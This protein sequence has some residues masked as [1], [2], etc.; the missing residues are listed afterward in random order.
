MQLYDSIAGGIKVS[1]P[2]YPIE[3]VTHIKP[4]LKESPNVGVPIRDLDED[5]T[6][7]YEIM[8]QDG[9]M[10][11]SVGAGA[12]GVVVDCA[13]D[14]EEALNYDIL[15]KARIPDKQY[16]TDLKEVLPKMMEEACEALE[17]VPA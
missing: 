2:P 14:A 8:M 12:V 16:R 6:Y 9:E 5:S 10:V 13:D 15:E 1:I 17:Y 3:A 11:H 4:I 7:F